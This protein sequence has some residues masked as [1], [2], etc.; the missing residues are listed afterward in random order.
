MLLK[1]EPSEITPFST[2]FFSVSGGGGSPL[3]PLATPLLILLSIFEI[4]C[5]F[6]KIRQI[7]EFPNPEQSTRRL[8]ESTSIKSNKNNIHLRV[9]TDVGA[10]AQGKALK[11]NQ[12]FDQ[13]RIFLEHIQNIPKD[14]TSSLCRI[15]QLRGPENVRSEVNFSKVGRKFYYWV[16]FQN[17]H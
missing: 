1:I 13:N 5:P 16:N 11:G 9:D 14:Y 4:L 7:N 10:I 17:M 15:L 3:S 12:I 2:T 6:P 8:L